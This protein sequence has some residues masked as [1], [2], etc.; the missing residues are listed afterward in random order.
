MASVAFGRGIAAI[1]T[2]ALGFIWLGWGLS[3]LRALPAA[4][5]LGYFSVTGA[6][7][8]F[9]VT[10]VG[11][12]RKMMRAQGGGLRSTLSSIREILLDWKAVVEC[13]IVT[14]NHWER[15][16]GKLEINVNWHHQEPLHVL[17]AGH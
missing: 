16:T 13:S 11:R 9:A 2:T 8:A 1:I 15:T 10:A 6:L 4:I 14:R 5:W 17:T 3:V 12:G 7:M